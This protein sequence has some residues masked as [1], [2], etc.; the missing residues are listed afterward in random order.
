[1]NCEQ[2]SELMSLELDGLLSAPQ[3]NA[4]YSHIDVCPDCQAQWHWMQLVSEALE[5]APAV[6]APAGMMTGVSLRIQKRVRRTA[7]VQR[8]TLVAATLLLMAAA[9]Y[10]LAQWPLGNAASSSVLLRWLLGSVA[11]LG[12]L[13]APVGEAM[14]TILG[15]LLLGTSGYYVGL[16]LLAAILLLVVWVMVVSRAIRPARQDI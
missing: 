13:L 9:G 10:A 11:G 6:P 14:S 3:R 16:A 2:S 5:S 8:L 12:R 1:M 4:L 7:L 15:A